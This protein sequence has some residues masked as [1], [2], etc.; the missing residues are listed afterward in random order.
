[1]FEQLR[2][3]D[4]RVIASGLL[5][6]VIALGLLTL[7]LFGPDAARLGAAVGLIGLLVAMQVAILFFRP[8]D[9]SPFGQAR[10]AFAADDFVG[11]AAQLEQMIA[12]KPTV[13]ALTLL[14]NSYR[15]LGRLDDSQARLEQ[16]LALSPKNAFA[17]YGMGRTQLARGNF[18]A[19]ADWFDKA[20][21]AGAPAPVACDLGL[22][23]YL[24]GNEEAAL[25]TLQ[26]T[27]RILQI[28]PYRALIASAIL[29]HLLKQNHSAASAQAEANI[30]HS[31]DG[32]AY[33]QAEVE[34]HYDTPYGQALAQIVEEVEGLLQ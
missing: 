19:A 4:R 16:A 3:L 31:T 23:E 18:D 33:W 1:M 22:A 26:K 21:A 27:T 28:E 8:A 11:A 25:K 34:R 5:A 20:L 6:L 29:Y 15:Q 14:G 32:L 30:R 24:A 2:Y 17:L 10:A 7:T 13:R 12:V 9:R